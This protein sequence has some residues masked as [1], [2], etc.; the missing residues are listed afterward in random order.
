MEV[1]AILFNGRVSQ[2][3]KHLC[4]SWEIVSYKSKAIT[5][6]YINLH[7]HVRDDTV[8]RCPLK[9]LIELLIDKWTKRLPWYT[10]T[11]NG[12]NVCRHSAMKH[13]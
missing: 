10:L 12:I 7:Y 2:E 11:T 9:I 13:L 4:T 8:G 5:Q 1:E 3:A 6:L